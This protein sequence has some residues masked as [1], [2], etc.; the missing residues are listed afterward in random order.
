MRTIQLAAPGGL[1]RLNLVDTPDPGAPAPGEIRY[2][3]TQARS[4]IT[5][6]R[7]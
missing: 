3:C 6:M 2:G 4:T 1:D 7:W 5:I